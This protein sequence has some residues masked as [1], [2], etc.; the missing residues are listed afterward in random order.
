MQLRGWAFECRIN[1]EDPFANFAPSPGKVTLHAP[2]GG[3]GVRVDAGVETGSVIP[4]AYDSLAAKL[5]VHGASRAE[6]LARLRRAL[7]E[8]RIEGVRTT[9]PFHRRLAAHA[10]FAAGDLHTKFLEEH[11]VLLSLIHISEPTRPY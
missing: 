6:A 8:Y 9:L 5:I 11:K 10:A 3:P 2:P 4:S 7:A 1:A